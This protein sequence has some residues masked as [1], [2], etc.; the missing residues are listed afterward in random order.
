MDTLKSIIDIVVVT[1]LM[2][3]PDTSVE[4]LCAKLV[5][6]EVIS[7]G[8]TTLDGVLKEFKASIKIEDEVSEIISLCTQFLQVFQSVP[9]FCKRL[10][11]KINKELVNEIKTEFKF[12]IKSLL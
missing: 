8:V 9:G 3:I 2:E 4:P 10:A 7:T 6:A 1:K 11:K 5:N 12:D